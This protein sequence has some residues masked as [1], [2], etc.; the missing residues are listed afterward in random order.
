MAL[1]NKYLL[2][3]LK[4]INNLSNVKVLYSIIKL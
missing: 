2:H 4:K 3:E 1:D